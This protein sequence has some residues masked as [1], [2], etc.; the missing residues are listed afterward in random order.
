MNLVTPE[1][2]KSMG[3]TRTKAGIVKRATLAAV[4]VRKQSIAPVEPVDERTLRFTIST[5]AVDRD[6]DV[7][8]P[9]GWQ[10]D[11]YG[12]NPVVLWSHQTAML[13]IGKTLDVIRTD[14]R[15][16]AVV[17]FLPPEGYGAASQFADEVYK[18]A[19]D[20]FLAAT[21]VGFRPLSWDVTEDPERGADD[22]WPGVDFHV[23]EL[24]ELSLVSVPANPEA[25]IE[26]DAA[27]IEEAVAGFGEAGPARLQ[28]EARARRRRAYTAALLGVHS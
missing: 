13:P 21:S 24:V 20:G 26:P 7:I 22:W 1:R 18:L 5:G 16:R 12:L 25:L 17:R 3:L 4:G 15:L 11:A 14:D 27:D 19:R 10:I 23:Q 28:R 6:R 8:D 2:F 9:K